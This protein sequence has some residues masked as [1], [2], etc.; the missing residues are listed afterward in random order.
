MVKAAATTASLQ[1]SNGDLVP[2]DPLPSNAPDIATAMSR[3]QRR[4]GPSGSTYF[5]DAPQNGAVDGNTVDTGPYT[6]YAGFEIHGSNLVPG[7]SADDAIRGGELGGDIYAGDGND[8][9]EGGGLTKKVV[10]GAGDDAVHLTV[11]GTAFGGDGNDYLL[12]SFSNDLLKGEAGNDTL[13]GGGGV[14]QLVGGAGADTFLFRPGDLVSGRYDGIL[15]FQSGQDKIDLRAF[16]SNVNVTF[17]ASDPKLLLIDVPH[18]G[19][20]NQGVRVYGDHVAVTD[21][22][23]A[24]G[25]KFTG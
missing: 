8:I 14:D 6:N 12:G 9:V 16:G 3:L 18:S 11:G 1:G 20:L 24:D 21:L 2:G 15:D 5:I 13:I 25:A 10:G 22:L 19:Q 17:S 4:D 7:R 23:L